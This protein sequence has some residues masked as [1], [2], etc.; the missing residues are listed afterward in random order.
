MLD[1]MIRSEEVFPIGIFTRTHGVQGEVAMSFTDD[2]FDRVECPYL[3][4]SMD[5]ILVPFFLEEYRF[6]GETIALIKV[7]RIDTV[8]QARV[9]IN[10]EVFFPKCYANDDETDNYSW[11]YFVG[12]SAEDEESGLLGKIVAVDDSTINVLFVIGRPVGGEFLVPAQEVFI[13]D[14]DYDKRRIMFH[15]PDGL[16]E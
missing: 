14:I 7:Q 8:E 1:T 3:L 13:T 5:G 16:L 15:L 4:C 10:K 9:F 12:F 11:N 6:K 2:I